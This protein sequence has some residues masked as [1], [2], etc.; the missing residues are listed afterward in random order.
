MRI[1]KPSLQTH[2]GLSTQ[3]Y[4]FTW[5]I[6][7][8]LGALQLPALGFT[9]HDR[10]ITSLGLLCKSKSDTLPTQ[11]PFA[12]GLP[13][14]A[15]D[16][17]MLFDAGALSEDDVV[18]GRFD[19]ARVKLRAVNWQAP[20]DAVDLFGGFLGKAK[21]DG[22]A[23]TFELNPWSAL[24]NLDMGRVYTDKCP[25]PRYARGLCRNGADVGGLSD[26]PD[27]AQN[28]KSAPIGAVYSAS[29]F[30]LT[31]ANVA[32]LADGYANFGIVR[33][34]SGPNAPAE[35]DVVKSSPV[36]GGQEIWLNLPAFD[37]PEL[38][39]SVSLER[40]CNRTD[41]DCRA[42]ANFPNFGGFNNFPLKEGLNSIRE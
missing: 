34:E 16:A 37:L 11:F 32:A 26:G 24:L 23:V 10:D 38:G 25:F 21:H 39:Q 18:S 27:I 14:A 12:V 4:C 3:T 13:N 8:V 20:D 5:S 9:S 17:V 22:N 19:G 28:T 41:I 2:F 30:V 33:F 1:V 35:F 15:L 7:P 31:G 6:T 36:Q 42:R 40:G 29:H